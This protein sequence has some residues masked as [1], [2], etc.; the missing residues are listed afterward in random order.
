MHTRLWA[1]SQYQQFPCDLNAF[2]LLHTETLRGK[3]VTSG[4]QTKATRAEIQTQYFLVALSLGLPL[5]NFLA[6]RESNG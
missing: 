2:E 1:V 5:N 4:E 6:F 3:N